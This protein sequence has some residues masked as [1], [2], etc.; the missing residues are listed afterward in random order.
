MPPMEQERTRQ[1]AL[2]RH[3]YTV[4]AQRHAYLQRTL[5]PKVAEL[6]ELDVNAGNA[7]TAVA[8]GLHST[9]SI[10]I[11]DLMPEWE[12]NGYASPTAADADDY[13]AEADNSPTVDQM[14]IAVEAVAE[15]NRLDLL[16]HLKGLV[17]PDFRKAI[18]ARAE[19]EL[20]QFIA[21]TGE[22][23]SERSPSQSGES[24]SMNGGTSDPTE[25]A[26]SAGPTPASSTP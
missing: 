16:K 9:L 22:P 8:G 11:P 15:V 21:S 14:V 12:W 5:G 19:V 6:G 10:F 3:T 13:D 18:W 26:S 7:A 23:A 2:G 25:D 17:G 4:I 24:P 1:I 20:T